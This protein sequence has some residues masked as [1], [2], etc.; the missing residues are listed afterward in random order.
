MLN[1]VCLCLAAPSAILSARDSVD[2]LDA[3]RGKL[4]G[5]LAGRCFHLPLHLSSIR[6][7]GLT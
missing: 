5:E 7:I 3:Y 4:L 6:R 1:L 2:P